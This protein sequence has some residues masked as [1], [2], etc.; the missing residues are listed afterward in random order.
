LLA[1][2]DAAEEQPKLVN[3]DPYGAGWMSRARPTRWVDE[4]PMLID[5]AA[6]RRHILKIEPEASFG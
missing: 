6:Y 3:I 4:K 1:G 2:N 5:A